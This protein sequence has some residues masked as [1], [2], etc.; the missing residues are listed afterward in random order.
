MINTHIPK[1]DYEMK[2]AYK[3]YIFGY[4]CKNLLGIILS[5]IIT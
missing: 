1:K 5:S 2:N 3:E 4:N